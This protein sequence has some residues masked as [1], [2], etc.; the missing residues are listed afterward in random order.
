[1]CPSPSPKCTSQI[2][3]F[4]FGS[5]FFLFDEGLM[6]KW[7]KFLWFVKKCVRCLIEISITL[8]KWISLH[9]IP[10]I[11]W[12]HGIQLEKCVGRFKNYV[13][14]RGLSMVLRGQ[15]PSNSVSSEEYDSESQQKTFRQHQ[16]C[17]ETRD[18]K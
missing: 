12:T 2:I 4:R 15:N 11:L 18:Q 6:K 1:M 17:P 7:K 14:G 16:M 8:S 5:L 13:K 9:F 10:L 3:Q